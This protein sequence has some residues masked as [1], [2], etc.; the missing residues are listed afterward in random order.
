MIHPLSSENK[1]INK[2]YL[3]KIYKAIEFECV[4]YIPS[5]DFG[6]IIAIDLWNIEKLVKFLLSYNKNI[7]SPT[8]FVPIILFNGLGTQYS[9][10]IFIIAANVHSARATIF[11]K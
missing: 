8:R 4:R 2:Q 1:L 7:A 5:S 6:V 9:I 3:I 11:P 10:T